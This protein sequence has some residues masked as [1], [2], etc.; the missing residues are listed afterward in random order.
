MRNIDTVIPVEVIE[1]KN[2]LVNVKSLLQFKTTGG[3][4]VNNPIIYNIPV[5][6][7]YGGGCQI[8][9]RLKA[10]DRGLL[11][12]SKNDTAEYKNNNKNPSLTNNLRNFD[13]C[14]G[15]FIPF[16]FNEAGDGVII[17]NNN[18]VVNILDG[19]INIEANNININGNINV[20]GTITASGEITSGSVTL[21]GHAHG[22]EDTQPNGAI[23]NKNTEAG[24]G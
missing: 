24:Q 13:F 1:Y 12:A 7:L 21:T 10:G 4:I 6:M 8:S 9:F 23:V 5:M 14:N 15:F 20:S 22:Y 16:D 11:I 18:T 17:K 19:Q 3:D 2:K